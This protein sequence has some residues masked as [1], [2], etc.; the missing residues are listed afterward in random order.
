MSAANIL[1]PGMPWRRHPSRV[2]TAGR[3][4]LVLARAVVLVLVFEVS[5]GATPKPTECKDVGMPA[6]SKHSCLDYACM[7]LCHMSHVSKTCAKTCGTCGSQLAVGLP[8]VPAAPK[9]MSRGASNVELAWELPESACPV[10]TAEL[11]FSPPVRGRRSI[12][13]SS[14]SPPYKHKA[15]SVLAD[16][17]YTVSIRV[18]SNFGWSAPSPKLTVPRHDWG[19]SHNGEK[20]EGEEDKSSHMPP[21]DRKNLKSHQPPSIPSNPIKIPSQ[22][23][24]TRKAT[25]SDNTGRIKQQTAGDGSSSSVNARRVNDRGS[26]RSTRKP[27]PP[28]APAARRSRK[29]R[30]KNPKNNEEIHKN[31]KHVLI[32]RAKREAREHLL[33]MK[34]QR[35]E[36]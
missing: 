34:R 33:E 28:S 35:S 12:L 2:E 15:S 13:V 31:K 9:I 1:T 24:N 18:K 27:S 26:S 10:K 3:L 22:N 32:Q 29:Q 19:V 11:T 17:Q 16:I 6:S 5:V 8:G 30:L 23:G 21:S 7:N 14:Q 20:G 4:W 36:L 25:V